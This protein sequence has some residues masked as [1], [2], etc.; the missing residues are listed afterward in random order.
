MAIIPWWSE[1]RPST[2]DAHQVAVHGA[3]DTGSG[4]AARTASAVLVGQVVLDADGQL[5]DGGMTRVS[6]VMGT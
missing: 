5:V 4:R 3:G 6:S 2:R 1:M